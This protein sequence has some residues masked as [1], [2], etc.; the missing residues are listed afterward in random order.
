M[1]E[2]GLDIEPRVVAG[3]IAAWTVAVNSAA[4][5]PSASRRDISPG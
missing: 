4:N 1:A 5:V 3:E 2:R